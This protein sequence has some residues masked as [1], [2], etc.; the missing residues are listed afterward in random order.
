MPA[1]AVDCSATLLGGRQ[2]SCSLLAEADTVFTLQRAEI[3]HRFS[4]PA[5]I[6]HFIADDMP[7]LSY[8]TRQLSFLTGQPQ[9]WYITFSQLMRNILSHMFELLSAILLILPRLLMEIYTFFCSHIFYAHSYFHASI[10]WAFY[11]KR[12]LDSRNI[13]IRYMLSFS[14]AIFSF[15]FFLAEDIASS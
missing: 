7:F 3:L 15:S 6:G 14:Y 13:I 5:M 12:Y 1:A 9:I 11:W 4:R 10:F 2:Q 8:I